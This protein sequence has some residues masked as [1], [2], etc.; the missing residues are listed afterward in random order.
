[1]ALSPHPRISGRCNNH[2]NVIITT[3]YNTYLN[4]MLSFGTSTAVSVDVALAAARTTG[5]SSALSALILSLR[6]FSLARYTR[7]TSASTKMPAWNT[8]SVTVADVYL[9]AGESAARSHVERMPPRFVM[10]V[11][12]ASDVARRMSGAML[13][14]IHVPSGGAMQYVPVTERKSEPYRTWL[15]NDPVRRGEGREVVQR[16]WVGRR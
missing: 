5:S 7:V 8:S 12:S 14:A 9:G 15:L 16:W 3:S 11:K 4:Q 2:N 1:M 6:A 10:T 13:F